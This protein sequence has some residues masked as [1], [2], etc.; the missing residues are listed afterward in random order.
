MTN[1]L[2]SKV[3]G[4]ILEDVETALGL[5]QPTDAKL[6]PFGSINLHQ[7]QAN[8]QLQLQTLRKRLQTSGQVPNLSK[9]LTI[10]KTHTN[11]STSLHGARDLLRRCTLRLQDAV[12]CSKSWRDL[13]SRLEI[14]SKTLNLEFMPDADPE[15]KQCFI[16]TDEF[17]VELKWN[18]EQKEV[19]MVK[20]DGNDSPELV[21]LLNHG[22]LKA[23]EAHLRGLVETH[24][25]AGSADK[26]EVGGALEAMEA[27]ILKLS[28]F[29]TRE[30]FGS[31]PEPAAGSEQERMRILERINRG[32]GFVV[33]AKGGQRMRVAYFVNTA[34]T[35]RAKQKSSL[36][37]NETVWTT[38]L[39]SQA[40]WADIWVEPALHTTLS[41]E[42]L[43]PADCIAHPAKFNQSLQ[44]TATK[45]AA[46]LRLDKPIPVAASLLTQIPFVQS[47]ALAQ[48][49]DSRPLL[50]SS[51]TVE[52]L[53]FKNYGSKPRTSF[54]QKKCGFVHGYHFVDTGETKPRGLIL[55]RVPFAHPSALAPILQLLRQQLVYN[56]LVES[57]MCEGASDESVNF[58]FEINCAAPTNVTVT[59]QHPV[60]GNIFSVELS[61]AL[62]G[63]VTVNIHVDPKDEQPQSTAKTIHLLQKS[64]SIPLTM[65]RLM[66]QLQ[67]AAAVKEL[68]PIAPAVKR[69]RDD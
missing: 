26:I 55:C 10:A 53:L 2:P 24:K 45:L 9:A 14:I 54:Y 65:H 27:D 37:Q 11:A 28:L 12:P 23:F 41:C 67:P 57:C 36:V 58:T 63:A 21:S 32:H 13:C 44:T 47:Q 30:F 34:T 68:E 18:N 69:K 46:V 52:E 29:D 56:H 43:I 51:V 6:H 59:G 5:N 1:P 49:T 40:H 39:L 17:Y 8:I 22:S 35:I 16:M 66:Q 15:A 4:A 19:E 31:D 20:L 62:G 38:E 25:L 50:D 60:S 7:Q 64:L 61:I 3:I 42:A 33:P 48:P